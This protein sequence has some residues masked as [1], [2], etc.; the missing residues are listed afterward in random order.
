MIT[1]DTNNA[2]DWVDLT[3]PKL[4]SAMSFYSRLFD[5]EL[6]T[7][8][9]PM[10]DYVIARQHGHQVA[11]LMERD[12]GITDAPP[13]WTMYINVG[14]ADLTASRAREAG[15]DVLEPPFDIPDGRISLVA[16]PTGAIFGVIATPL[17]HQDQK[18]F[19][20]QSGGVCWVELL[21]R[22]PSRA[23]GFYRATFGWK[24][25]TEEYDGTSYT[26]F[27][28]D[29]EGVAGMM[30]MPDEVP[31]EAPAHWAIYFAVDDC[32]RTEK[33]AAELG[34]QILRGTTR[35]AAGEFAVLA[36]PQGASFHIMGT[37]G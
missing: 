24:A 20:S 11:G 7:T 27:D 8:P 16:D 15:G 14:D 13:M 37:S 34:G 36:D 19:S 32:A 31:A 28:L 26:T 10:G 18:W 5:W 25:E 30:M 4:E 29:G 21:T 17:Q 9:S 1:A 3:T 12:A 2:P 6:E 35:I 33:R 22:D 23:E